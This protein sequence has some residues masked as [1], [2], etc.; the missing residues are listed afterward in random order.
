MGSSVQDELV[1]KMQLAPSSRWR[2][3]STLRTTLPMH[4][5][6]PRF[7]GWGIDPTTGS[8]RF[9]RSLTRS[10]STMRVGVFSASAT[11]VGILQSRVV[12][13]T[14]HLT[15]CLADQNGVPYPQNTPEHEE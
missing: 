4:W 2:A 15:R 1:S 9:R 8:W 12:P 5:L 11:N 10:A 6:W 14:Q 3:V 13:G 7:A